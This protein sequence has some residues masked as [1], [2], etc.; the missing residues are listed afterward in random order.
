MPE[1]LTAQK[2]LINKHQRTN[3]GDEI[4]ANRFRNPARAQAQA[5]S[6]GSPA[7]DVYFG[8]GLETT[9]QEDW[10][11]MTS[12]DLAEIGFDSAP[13]LAPPSAGII[14]SVYLSHQ[15]W[16]GSVG[17][18]RARMINASSGWMVIIVLGKKLNCTMSLSSVSLRR[19]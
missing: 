17:W 4:M 15:H 13:A 8:F 19:S 14:I 18:G 11:E 1:T 5:L 2:G 9:E 7:G 3:F 16:L 10:E 12:F 6:L